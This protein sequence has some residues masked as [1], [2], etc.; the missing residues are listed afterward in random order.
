MDPEQELLT[1][2]AMRLLTSGFDITAADV[3][4]DAQQVIDWHGSTDDLM[5]F[6]EQRYQWSALTTAR[7]LR[8]LLLALGRRPEHMDQLPE[9]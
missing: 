8:N 6:I 7:Y 2:G 4:A 3:N 1:P 5:L 9:A